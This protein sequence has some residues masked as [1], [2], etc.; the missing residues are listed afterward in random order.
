MTQ[1][2]G[3]KNHNPVLCKQLKQYIKHFIFF[4]LH[5][6]WFVVAILKEK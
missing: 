5:L 2:C 6:S 3:K 1:L 4:S